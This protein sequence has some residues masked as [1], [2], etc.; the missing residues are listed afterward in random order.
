M[1][2]VKGRAGQKV[3]WLAGT[4]TGFGGFGGSDGSW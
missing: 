4:E 2:R 1:Q 3:S